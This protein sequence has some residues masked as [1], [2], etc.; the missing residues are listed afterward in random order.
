MKVHKK[1]IFENERTSYYVVSFEANP[2]KAILLGRGRFSGEWIYPPGEIEKIEDDLVYYN[3][4]AV[5]YSDG[6]KQYRQALVVNDPKVLKEKVDITIDDEIIIHKSIHSQYGYIFS[7]LH[8]IK[9]DKVDDPLKRGLPLYYTWLKAQALSLQELTGEDAFLKFLPQSFVAQFVWGEILVHLVKGNFSVTPASSSLLYHKISFPKQNIYFKKYPD[10]RKVVVLEKNKYHLVWEEF[11]GYLYPHQETPTNIPFGL[12]M[13]N[14]LGPYL[15]VNDRLYGTKVL[16]L[17]EIKDKEL[18]IEKTLTGY[19]VSHPYYGSLEIPY[20]NIYIF[21]I[22]SK[23]K[24]TLMLK[25][26][27]VSDS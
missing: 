25:Y 16:G 18:K 6:T 3:T 17:D 20:Q 27:D 22:R 5:E 9:L 24:D 2:K 1:F 8:P 14:K 23:H 15:I 21:D 4:G 7:L 10:G 11:N 13:H 26:P 19:K 12:L